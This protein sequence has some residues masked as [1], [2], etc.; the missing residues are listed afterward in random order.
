[1]FSNGKVIVFF[2]VDDIIIMFHDRHQEEWQR[3]ERGLK[4]HFKLTGGKEA[5]WFLKMRITRD[6]ANRLIWLSQEQY[7]E[8]VARRFELEDEARGWPTTP[9]APSVML[10]PATKGD[11]LDEAGR[12]SYQAMVGSIIYASIMTRPDVAKAAAVLSRFLHNLGIA[13]ERAARHYIRYLYGTRFLALQA[14]GSSN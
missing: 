7:V 11:E 9:L 10:K 2:F 12:L 4:N 5:S 13:Y 1:M 3:I 8:K 6:R 14:D